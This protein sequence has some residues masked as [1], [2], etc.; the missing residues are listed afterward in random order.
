MRTSS[1]LSTAA[2]I[3]FAAT[4]GSN[5]HAQGFPPIPPD[6]AKQIPPG[7][8][9]GTVTTGATGSTPTTAT[10]SGKWS[11]PLPGVPVNGPQPG[12][13]EWTVL[14]YADADNDLEGPI[15]DD[16]DEMETIGS[17]QGVNVVMQ[18][19]RWRPPP[20]SPM[21][22][23]DD[24]TNGDWDQAKRYFITRDDGSTKINSLE[25]QDLG[26]VDM[27]H[28]N[29]LHDF[30]VWGIKKFPAKKYALVMED[31]GSGWKG[32]FVD[33]KAA[34]FA[35]PMVLMY[36]DELQ[37]GLQTGLK[38][39]GI[40]KLDLFAADACL[41]STIEVI[42]AIAP[43]SKYVVASEELQPGPGFEYTL[44]LGAVA[45]NPKMDGIGLGKA[46]V[47][48]MRAGYGPASKMHDP[49]VTS[50]L[51]D[52]AKIPAVRTAVDNLA[53]TMS[54]DLESNKIPLG[55]ASE[56]VDTFGAR[57]NPISGPKEGFADLVQVAAV[58]RDT[59]SKSDAKTAASS[60]IKALDGARLDKHMGEDRPNAR[61][62]TV[63]LP[64]PEVVAKGLA[65][66]RKTPFGKTSPWADLLNVYGNAF[67]VSVAPKV[68]NVVIAKPTGNAFTGD[69][70]VTADIEGEVRNAVMVISQDFLGTKVPVE[71]LAVT[72]P[73]LY[74]KLP[75]GPGVTAWKKT[76]NTVSAKWTPMYAS[77]QGK[78]GMEFP[79][80]VN[81]VRL[82][83]T[84]FDADVVL[85]AIGGP[86]ETVMLR[87][88]MP[89]GGFAGSK[90][91][92]GYFIDV[93]QGQE[94]YT[95]FSPAKLPA[96]KVAFEPTYTAVD[97][98]GKAAQIKVPII[99]V[100]WDKLEDLKIVQRPMLPGKYD[101]TVLAED[102]N[103]HVGVG[104]GSTTIP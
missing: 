59:S 99:Q 96:G 16:L 14:V 98:S 27:A 78:G 43:F 64:P 83:S 22:S 86:A 82:D 23:R 12:L 104:K 80:V 67:S 1:T 40:A 76:K 90:L 89:K 79:L 13:A 25:L 30:L 55:M 18:I 28:Y 34:P 45:A 24:K 94:F 47:N 6:L 4:F 53:K 52:T 41:M 72:D 69:R 97:S 39:A 100:K 2:L 21:A 92:T 77:L 68:S 32:A 62:M 3:A 38:D 58:V 15:L 35:K 26:E 61:G 11:G 95:P 84:S 49:T 63:W 51:W 73:A 88:S 57:T 56:V 20:N 29:Q 101:I 65:Q 48:A 85:R 10:G 75:E 42:D 50:A 81:R 70:G 36:L 17:V 8:I 66:Y 60:L 9:P 91:L 93:V 33:D 46:F 7:L 74:K 103:G 5:G 102:F 31:H 44:A 37:T 54:K 87:F 19:D 71:I